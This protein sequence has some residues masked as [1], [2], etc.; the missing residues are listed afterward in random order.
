MSTLLSALPADARDRVAQAI[1]EAFPG[2][3]PQSL[4]PVHGGLSG[5]LVYKLVVDERPFVLRVI[6]EHSLLNDPVRQLTCLRLAAEHGIAPHLRYASTE[7]ALSIS[8]YI[9]HRP[10]L[11]ELRRSA[12][13]VAHFG[14]LL[15]RLHA[16]PAFP[17]FLDAFQMIEGGLAQLAQRG[18]ALPEPTQAALA[19]FEP[20][21]RALQPHLIAAPCHND[22]NP[23]NV[24]YDGGRLWLVDWETAC[25]GDPMLDIAGLIH[26]FLFDPGQ[27]A[28]L[29]QSYFQRGPS[30][31][32]LAKLTLMKHVSWWFYAIVFLL[33]LQ[34]EEVSA[35]EAVDPEK[36]PSFAEMLAAVGR[37]E[38]RL[39]EPGARRR[40]SLVLAKQ[41]LDAMRRPAYREAHARLMAG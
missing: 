8:A 19:E 22:L 32:D 29:L 30:E 11:P 3:R 5:A 33:S 1:G 10:A 14:D 4:E 35:V 21:K 12:D 39:H 17:V 40:M 28:T 36:L 16:G 20:V 25:M 34:G 31:R 15:R 38:L 18:V 27:E 24:L 6:V 2:A 9:A 41:S 26:W 13:L 37:G 23:A 7:L